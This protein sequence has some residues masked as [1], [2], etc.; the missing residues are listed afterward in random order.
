M[1]EFWYPKFRKD[2]KKHKYMKI[3]FHF[4]RFGQIMHVVFVVNT[5]RFCI[6]GDAKNDD[7]RIVLL[8]SSF[9]HGTVQTVLPW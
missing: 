2:F 9:E 3:D 1:L 4:L 7:F 5:L 6:L 8:V